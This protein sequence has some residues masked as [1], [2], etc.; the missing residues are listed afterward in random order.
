[1]TI[2]EIRDRLKDRNL[3]AVSDA[4]GIPYYTVQRFAAGTSVRPAYE[5]VKALQDYLGAR[6]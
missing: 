3:K 4:T 2:E 6:P 1:M 5:T